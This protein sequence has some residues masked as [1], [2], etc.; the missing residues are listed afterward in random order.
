MSTV[1]D[2]MS[3][4]GDIMKGVGMGD[5]I[6]CYLNTSTLFYFVSAAGCHCFNGT[7][8]LHSIHDIPSHHD[9]INIISCPH[10]S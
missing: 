5:T 4:V 6:F 1:G 9:I 10:V 3:T 8:H 7:E 2:I